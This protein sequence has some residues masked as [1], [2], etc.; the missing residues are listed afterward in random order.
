M[1]IWRGFGILVGIFWALCGL[2][3]VDV[4]DWRETGLMI[5][6]FPTGI[7]SWIVGSIVNKHRQENF[8]SLFFIPMEFW[9]IICPIIGILGLTFGW[10]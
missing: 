10:R 9:G 6:M 4:F 7:F 1:V 8:H 3:F 5:A 2:L